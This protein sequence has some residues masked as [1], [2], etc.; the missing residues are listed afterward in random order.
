MANG[1]V[2]LERVGDHEPT[3]YAKNQSV[4]APAAASLQRPWFG[5][6]QRGGRMRGRWWWVRQRAGAGGAAG[7]RQAFH[8][9]AAGVWAARG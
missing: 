7:T 4:H 8:V 6:A 9:K 3:G 5:G 1:N 2:V